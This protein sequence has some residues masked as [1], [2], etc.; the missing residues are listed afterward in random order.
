MFEH[1]RS[2]VNLFVIS[3]TWLGLFKDIELLETKG[4]NPNL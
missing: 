2:R 1:F 3:V 4:E